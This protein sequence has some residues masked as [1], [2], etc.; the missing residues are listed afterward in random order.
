MPNRPPHSILDRPAFEQLFKSHFAYLCNF[1]NQYVQDQDA[2]QEICQKVFIRLWEKREEM[3]P[4][5]SIQSY[6]FTAVKNRC[7]NHLRDTKKYRSR[8]L[9]LDCGDLDFSRD[10]QDLL[11]AEELQQ[12]IEAALAALP[13]KCRQVFEMS[14]YRN[15]KYQE[16]A[17]ELAISPKTV[18]AHMSKA[19][20]TLREALSDYQLG[21]LL[22]WLCQHFFD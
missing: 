3:D 22:L 21:V 1:A 12:R 16:I 7:L 6:L 5:Q 20:K 13:D 2:A 4:Q 17:E 19:L 14:R 11:A 8:I 15:M 9:D 18:E 10:D